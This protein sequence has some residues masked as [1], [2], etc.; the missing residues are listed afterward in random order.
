MKHLFA[1][2]LILLLAAYPSWAVKSK[3]QQPT[4]ASV[5]AYALADVKRT[6]S[7]MLKNE[8]WSIASWN[9]AKYIQVDFGKR[10][11]IYDWKGHLL[12]TRKARYPTAGMMGDYAEVQWDLLNEKKEVYSETYGCLLLH[13][14]KSGWLEVAAA[15]AIEGYGDQ[16][17]KAKVPASVIKR[18][19]R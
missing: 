17:K 1:G 12:Q 19:D 18:L 16:L 10:E 15:D 7:E 4:T 9:Q 6:R 8:K 13:Y 5:L 2:L 3:R 14:G 11:Y